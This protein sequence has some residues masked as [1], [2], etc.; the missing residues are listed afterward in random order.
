MGDL[1]YMKTNEETL[2]EMTAELLTGAVNYYL[3]EFDVAV[4]QFETDSPRRLGAFGVRPEIEIA[5]CELSDKERIIK[6]E[7]YTLKTSFQVKGLDNKNHIYY[8]ALAIQ[9]AIDDDVTF[10]GVADRVTLTRKKYTQ[11][12]GMWDVVLTLRATLEVI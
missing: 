5:E 10:G 3:S 7:A 11:R 12:D 9:K 8:Y 1:D 4:P 2:L 6:L